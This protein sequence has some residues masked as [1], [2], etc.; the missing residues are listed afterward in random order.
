MVS[1]YDILLQELP[2]RLEVLRRPL[3]GQAS[4]FFN[5]GKVW[6]QEQEE[7]LLLDQTMK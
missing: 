5:E 6:G 4:Y 2:L 1:Q 3:P 7:G